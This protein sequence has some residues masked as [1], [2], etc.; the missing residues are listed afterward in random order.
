[1][2]KPNKGR[3]VVKADAVSEKIGSIIVPNSS[4]EKSRTGKVLAV[5]SDINDIGTGNRVIFNPYSAL[6]YKE[7]NN[8]FLI[9]KAEDIYGTLD[10]SN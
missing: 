8:D 4:K 9:L 7:G 1:M 10:A 2:I 5:A 6:E 3:V